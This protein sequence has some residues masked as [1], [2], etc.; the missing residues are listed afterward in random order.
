MGRLH[1]PAQS[2]SSPAMSESD[3]LY[4]ASVDGDDD[5]ESDGM[6]AAA[7]ATLVQRASRAG[8][9]P[10]TPPVFSFLARPLL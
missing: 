1:W 7:R 10:P 8:E 6:G 3:T 2:A 9:V 5:T 4:V